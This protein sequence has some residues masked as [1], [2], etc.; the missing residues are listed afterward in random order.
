MCVSGRPNVLGR[1]LC[2][3][4]CD[5]VRMCVCACTVKRTYQKVINIKKIPVTRCFP[6]H[7]SKVRTGQK[8]DY[9]R[10]VTNK[11]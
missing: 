4:V 2:V 10:K 5:C 3:R 8:G 6:N 1:G 11:N 9:K 7:K